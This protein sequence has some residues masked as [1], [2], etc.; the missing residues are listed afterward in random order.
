MAH[1]DIITYRYWNTN[2]VPVA[3]VAIEGAASDIAAYIGGDDNPYAREE[4][5][6]QRVVS[7]GAKLTEEEAY[8]FL[9]QLKKVDLTYRR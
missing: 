7:M 2:G 5:T 9:P 1:N 4:E 3:I 6:I 8:R